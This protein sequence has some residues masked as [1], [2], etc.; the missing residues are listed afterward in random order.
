MVEAQQANHRAESADEL[1]NDVRRRVRLPP[2]VSP[3]DAVRA[4]MCTFFQHV[5]ADDVRGVFEALPKAVQPI[6]GVC[7]AHRGERRSRFG[8]DE[9]VRRVGEHL[10]ASKGDAEDVT[11]AVLI[12]V[13]ARLPG[14][15]IAS[16]ASRLP[17]DLQG[18][19]IARRVALPS[20]PHPI[21]LAI[22]RSVGLP[23]GVDGLA[24]FATVVGLLTRRL[25]RGEARH[26]AE[27]LPQD[28]APLIDDYIDDRTES[29][30]H[31]DH[32]EFLN[33]VA[34][35]LDTDDVDEAEAVARAVFVSLEEYLRSDVYEHAM[36]QLPLRLQ[37][38]W[39][40]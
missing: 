3:E 39:V 28:L 18:L 24:A 11:S 8:R 6:V 23:D 32:E 38:L 26:V 35:E 4:V 19:W 15:K 33:L 16:A 22:E 27:N 29:P 2:G 34:R 14:G 9:L 13:S 12:A 36:R 30:A 5:S 7:I 17:P 1:A 20:E 10:H 21:T 31:F 25:T 37:E 40:R